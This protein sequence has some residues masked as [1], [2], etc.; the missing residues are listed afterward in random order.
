MDLNTLTFSSENEDDA[1]E[2]SYSDSALDSGKEKE[3][4][5]DGHPEAGNSAAEICTPELP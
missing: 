3:P 4:E 2:D 1:S 5:D